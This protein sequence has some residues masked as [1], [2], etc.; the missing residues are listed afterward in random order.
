MSQSDIKKAFILGHPV[1]QTR[2]PLIH[3]FWLKQFGLEGRYEAIDLLPEALDDFLS[4][5]ATSGYAGGNV[6]APHKEQT[7]RFLLDKGQ[8]T[9]TARRIGAVN[10]LYLENGVLTGDNTDAPGFIANLDQVLGANWPDSMRHCLVLGAGGAARAV[11]SG[12]LDRISCPIWLANRTRQKAEILQAFDDTRIQVI[13]W[14]EVSNAMAE[15]D[16]IV[17][18]TSLVMN[19][20]NVALP[21]SFSSAGK[22]AIAADIVYAPLE[23]AFL[24]EAKACGLRTVDGLGM[25]LHQAVPGFSRWFG[26]VPE[27]TPDLRAFIEQDLNQKNK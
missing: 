18:T 19:K 10:T 12:L 4:G 15:C 1:K 11:L 25:L 26:N 17:N 14:D 2:S 8:L 22:N 5:I 27:V 16:L 6:T 24:K 23:T 7:F 13:D 3:G 9:Q 21:F 20:D